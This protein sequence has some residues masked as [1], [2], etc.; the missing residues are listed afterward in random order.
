MPASASSS[1]PT[2]VTAWNT[3]GSRVSS[4]ML[5]RDTPASTRR[6]ASR[7][8]SAPFVVMAM[9]SMPGIA[10]SMAARSAHP[11]RASGSPPVRRRC[12]MPYSDAMR[13]KCSICSNVRMRSWVLNGTPSAGMQYTQR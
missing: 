1:L 9:S 12:L 5:T 4:E 6:F 8:S 2:R 10:M 7:G 11:R 13:T 3:S